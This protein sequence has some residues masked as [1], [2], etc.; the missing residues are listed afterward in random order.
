MNPAELN[1][2]P[3][4]QIHPVVVVAVMLII[5]ATYFALRRVYVFPYLRVLEDRERIFETADAE[6]AEATQCVAEANVE[7][8]R[9]I[10]EAVAEAEAMRAEAHAAAEGYHRDQVTKATNAA[11]ARLEEGRAQIAQARASELERLRAEASECVHMA[12]GQLVGTVD[13]DL[14]SATVDRLMSRQAN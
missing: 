5:V 11:A 8:E 14:V 3:I 12:C 6:N 2:N 13:E 1:L 7:S 9:T 4:D 10:A